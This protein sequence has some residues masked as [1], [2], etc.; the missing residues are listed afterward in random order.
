MSTWQRLEPSSRDRELSPGLEA[1][2]HDP[3]WLL[4]RQ[5]QFGEF[6]AGATGSAITT[7]VT[8]S[9]APLTGLRHG[10]TGAPQP[11]AVNGAPLEALVE[12]DDV[13]AAPTRRSRVRAGQH[14]ERLLTA[15]SLAKYVTTFRTAYPL[16]GD[17]AFAGRAIDGVALAADVRANRPLPA[18]VTTADKAAVTTVAQTWLAWVNGLVMSGALA[19][20]QH[21]RLEYAFATAAPD[22]ITLEADEYTDGRLDWHSFTA[23]GT[24]T[25]TGRTT[26]GPVTV[27]PSA[28]TFP[29][30]PASRLWEFEDSR[31]H[32]GAVEAEATDLGRML[33]SGF[34]LVYGADWMVVPLELPLGSVARINKLDVRDTFGKVTTVGP[35]DPTGSWNMFGLTGAT[36]RALLLAPALAQSLQGR[37]VEEVLLLRDETANL[38]WA[39]ERSLEG[40][41]GR[42][43]DQAQRAHEGVEPTP[44]PARPDRVLPYRLRTDPP[45]YWFPL[46]PQRAVPTNPSMSFKLAGAPSGRVL[47]P[48]ASDPNLRLREDEVPREGARVTRAYQLARWIDGGTYLWLGRRKGVGRGEGSS[49]L[50]FDTTDA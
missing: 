20:W 16:G 32:F 2:L 21:D 50:H 8:A 30:M 23:K 35:T 34:A 18:G 31:V 33:L 9:V 42:P 10:R 15:R 5:W 6:A 36:D 39:V 14:F 4:G 12:A 17:S 26:V 43:Q 41:D 48:L 1:R 22:G 7:E 40:P 25:T 46:L 37:D 29:G 28:V 38:A 24:P 19:G 47:A 45:P 49:G 3:L 27:V 44:P 13:H 11:Y